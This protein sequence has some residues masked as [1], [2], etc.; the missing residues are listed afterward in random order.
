MEQVIRYGV[1]HNIG[2][3]TEKGWSCLLN[4]YYEL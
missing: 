3:R 4:I 1:P 2:G